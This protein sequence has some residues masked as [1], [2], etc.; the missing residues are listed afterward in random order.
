MARDKAKDD[1]LYN[2]TQDYEKNYVVELYSIIDQ[3]NVR[4][5]LTEACQDNRIYH[6]THMEV[7]ELIKEELGLDIPIEE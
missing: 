6:S 7:Y 4:N 1:L 2:C 5:L 3:D